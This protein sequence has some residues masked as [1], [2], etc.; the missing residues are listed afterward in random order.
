M[1]VPRYIDKEKKYDR[2][3]EFRPARNNYIQREYDRTENT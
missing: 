1:Q 3:E 2:T